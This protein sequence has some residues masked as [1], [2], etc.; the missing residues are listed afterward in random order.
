MFVK[1]DS[2]T[3]EFSDYGLIGRPI[4]QIGWVLG[5]GFV[6]LAETFGDW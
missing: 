6:Q 1:I 3:P 4:A 2:L 5:G